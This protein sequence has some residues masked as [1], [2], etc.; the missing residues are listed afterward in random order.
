M[1][2]KASHREDRRQ[3]LLFDADVFCTRCGRRLRSDASQKRRIGPGCRRRERAEA[4]K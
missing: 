4:R 2:C 1:R 3:E